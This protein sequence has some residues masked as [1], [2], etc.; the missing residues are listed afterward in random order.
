MAR[1][2]YK[3]KFLH[4]KKETDQQKANTEKT[5]DK[6]SSQ[7]LNAKSKQDLEI[8]KTQIEVDIENM[9]LQM[10]KIE[11]SLNGGL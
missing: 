7:I 10:E 4:K 1:L 6:L 11:T 5:E 9:R 2:F 8:A 3:E